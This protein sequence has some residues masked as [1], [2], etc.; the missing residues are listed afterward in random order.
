MT[1]TS[2]FYNKEDAWDIAKELF[3]AKPQNV[4][5][6]YTIMKIPGEDKPEFVLMLPFTPASS[7]TNTRNNMIAWMAAR[8]DG[9]HY[10]EL[11]LYKLPKNIEIDGPLQIESRIDQDTEISKQLSLWDQKGSS[12]IRGNLL[13]L[14]IG[15]NFLYVEPIY[16]QS[17]K[18][19]SIP[20]MKRVVLAYQ[21]R[22]VMTENIGSALTQLFGEGAPQPTTPGQSIPTPAESPQ[23]PITEVD[24]P[25]LVSIIDQMNQIRTLLDSLEIQLKG[26]QSTPSET[27]PNE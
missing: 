2:V 27:P 14:P 19:G 17:D 18:G 6:Y 12:V 8:M 26:L 15:G 4:A 21:D 11:L 10:G 16:L 20:E 22:L 13:A 7:A 5:P 25:N 9:E 3:E 1:N 23:T 24:E